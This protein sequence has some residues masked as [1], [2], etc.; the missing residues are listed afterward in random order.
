MLRAGRLTA[1]QQRALDELWPRYGV[2]L[3]GSPP[4]FTAVFARTAPLVIEIGFGNGETLVADAQAH[5]QKNFLGIEVHTP[6]IGRLMR[7]LKQ[8]EIEN[9]RVINHDAAEVLRH[10]LR[11]GSVDAVNIFFPDPWPKKRHHKRRL[12][13]P[14]FLQLVASALRPGGQLHIATDWENYAEHIDECLVASPQ[15]DLQQTTEASRNE[16]KFERRGRRLGHGV[17]DFVALR[18]SVTG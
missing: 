13:Q 14:G 12:I 3:A 8:L 6:G 16:T 7:Q 9:V 10:H 11:P 2:D 4:D 15:F 17:W 18:T 5:P 1:A